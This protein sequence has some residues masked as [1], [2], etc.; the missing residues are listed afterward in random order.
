[1]FESPK[2]YNDS[3]FKK[4]EDAKEGKNKA[5]ENKKINTNNFLLFKMYVVWV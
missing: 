4:I 5:E 3:G 1:M 2:L